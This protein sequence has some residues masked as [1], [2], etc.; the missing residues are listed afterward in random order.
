MVVAALPKRFLNSS[1][2]TRSVF[3][4]RDL[5]VVFTSL[6]VER[7]EENVIDKAADR[8][9]TFDRACV[10]VCYLND[11][12]VMSMSLFPSARVSCVRY[13]AAFSC[14]TCCMSSLMTDV[15]SL[16]VENLS[17]RSNQIR[18]IAEKSFAIVAS[19]C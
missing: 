3:H 18:V 17:E 13:T 19:S 6:Y 7:I 4:I 10:A 5:S 11:L 12:T 14:M 15:A 16:P 2:S 1:V 8:V 9:C